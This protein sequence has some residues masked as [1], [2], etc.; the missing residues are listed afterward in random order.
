MELDRP[1]PNWE[2]IKT[3]YVLHGEPPRV[4]AE[5]YNIAPQT[6]SNRASEENW[7]K[8]RGVIAKELRDEELERRKRLIT[9]TGQALETMIEN[10]LKQANEKGAYNP[11]PA[12][13]AHLKAWEM[14]LKHYFETFKGE[15]A[16]PGEP[17]GFVISFVRPENL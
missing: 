2:D 8:E 5:R 17:P 13:R 6:I 10:L 11:E 9:K 12:E 16:D 7:R 14:T 3:R 1:A 4:I 15:E